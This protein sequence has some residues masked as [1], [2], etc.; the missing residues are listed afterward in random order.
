DVTVSERYGDRLAE[1]WGR[2]AL[3][4]CLP[5]AVVVALYL[6]VR[7][8]ALG[9]ATAARNMIDAPLAERMLTMSIVVVQYL[10][11]LLFP[12]SLHMERSL[13]VATSP[14]DPAVL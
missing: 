13:P 4:R 8:M 5:Y 7:H 9:G 11:L 2:R 14:F 6:P 1:H 3:T 12:A 10:G